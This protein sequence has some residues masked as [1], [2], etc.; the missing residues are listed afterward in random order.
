M[1]HCVGR[2]TRYED[3]HRRFTEDILE[4]QRKR[5]QAWTKL[6]AQFGLSTLITDFEQEFDAVRRQVLDKQ[7]DILL[8]ARTKDDLTPLEKN[9]VRLYDLMNG[10]QKNSKLLLFNASLIEIARKAE[11]SYFCGECG[12]G[13]VIPDWNF[14]CRM[15]RSK[16]VPDRA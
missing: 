6:A 11:K 9:T 2:D 8:K 1:N 5:L 15:C 3:S 7:A 14:E 10:L 4:P 13:G 16:N 12:Y